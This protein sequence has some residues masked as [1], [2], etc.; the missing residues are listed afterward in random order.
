MAGHSVEEIHAAK[1]KFLIVF[2]ILAALT[3]ITML[4]HV[5]HLPYPWNWVVGL[6]IAVVKAA[7]VAAVFMH[8]VGEKALI[9]RTMLFT[10]IFCIG[11]MLLTVLS[12]FDHIP[13][14]F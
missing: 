14:L 13:K 4:A 1:K 8:M 5:V 3:V 2:A 11:L 6:A 12:F 9:N 10:V 7:L